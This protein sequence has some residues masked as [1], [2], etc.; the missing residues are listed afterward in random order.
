MSNTER[1]A[2]KVGHAQGITFRRYDRWGAYPIKAYGPGIPLDD[3]PDFKGWDQ[4]LEWVKGI[5]VS[6]EGKK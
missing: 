2:R 4:A 3:A 6:K 5:L 1:Q